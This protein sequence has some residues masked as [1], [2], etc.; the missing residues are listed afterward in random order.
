MIK[1]T[2]IVTDVT[3]EGEIIQLPDEPV[4]VN[5]AHVLTIR[6]NRDASIGGSVLGLRGGGTLFV[7]ESQEDIVE[8]IRLARDESR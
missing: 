8:L 2:V 5:P 7:R 3:T 6:R 1:V 4:Y